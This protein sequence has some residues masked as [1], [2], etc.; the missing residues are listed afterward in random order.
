MAFD[1]DLPTID[2]DVTHLPEYWHSVERNHDAINSVLKGTV[3][4]LSIAYLTR[5]FVSTVDSGIG[6]LQNNDNIML[7]LQDATT[8]IETAAQNIPGSGVPTF[9]TS[10]LLWNINFFEGITDLFMGYVCSQWQIIVGLGSTALNVIT[11]TAPYLFTT[12]VVLKLAPNILPATKLMVDKVITFFAQKY[13]DIRIGKLARNNREKIHAKY[14]EL[15]EGYVTSAPTCSEFSIEELI[16]KN[17]L[18]QEMFDNLRRYNANGTTLLNSYTYIIQTTD[19]ATTRLLT[20][21]MHKELEQNKRYSQYTGPLSRIVNNRYASFV[22]SIVAQFEFFIPSPRQIYWIGNML[23]FGV[24][25]ILRIR[26]VFKPPTLPFTLSWSS[27]P[28]MMITAANSLRKSHLFNTWIAK[29]AKDVRSIIAGYLNTKEMISMLGKENIRVGSIPIIIAVL[30]FIIYCIE[31]KHV[32]PDDTFDVFSVVKDIHTDDV[33]NAIRKIHIFSKQKKTNNARDFINKCDEDGDITQLCKKSGNV[34]Q[35]IFE[36]MYEAGD[37]DK[38]TMIAKL[39]KHAP[40]FELLKIFRMMDVNRADIYKGIPSNDRDVNIATV[41]TG[42]EVRDGFNPIGRDKNWCKRLLA[43]KNDNKRNRELFETLRK[44]KI[45]VRTIGGSPLQERQYKIICSILLHQNTP[46]IGNAIHYNNPWWIIPKVNVAA[47]YGAGTEDHNPFKLRWETQPSLNEVYDA[48]LTSYTIDEWRTANLSPFNDYAISNYWSVHN[49][50]GPFIDRVAVTKPE[51]LALLAPVCNDGS[52]LS[53]ISNFLDAK[54]STGLDMFLCGIAQIKYID[55]RAVYKKCEGLASRGDNLDTGC[56]CILLHHNLLDPNV[57]R[58]WTPYRTIVDN[59]TQP[60]RVMHDLM[61]ASRK[62]M[63]N[64][65]GMKYL[66]FGNLFNMFVAYV[67]AM[68]ELPEHLDETRWV[69]QAWRSQLTSDKIIKNFFGDFKNKP[70]DEIRKCAEKYEQIGI[71]IK[72]IA[73]ETSTLW[74]I[75]KPQN[76]P[77][78]DETFVAQNA[79]FS[80]NAYDHEYKYIQR[81]TD[82]Q[83]TGIGFLD[84]LWFGEQHRNA[85]P[86]RADANWPWNPAFTY[87]KTQYIECDLALVDTNAEHKK[88]FDQVLKTHLSPLTIIHIGNQRTK[89]NPYQCGKTLHNVV[90]SNDREFTDV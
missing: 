72:R 77:E 33:C 2:I 63:L 48:I 76:C 87:K 85:S 35:I 71:R 27:I 37:T 28:K 84:K 62:T 17:K 1:G 14:G 41:W 75:L 81:D 69:V 60:A 32:L 51:L 54:N 73:F 56:V 67:K 23:W 44:T 42:D 89:L 64:R 74:D 46:V 39:W 59:A 29:N 7:Y 43:V 55:K 6:F 4:C 86:P 80:K 38:K 18:A 70:N 47:M 8:T 34:V 50:Q 26:D 45:T 53:I 52:I 19:G 24:K 16:C 83:L 40:T 61:E 30:G 49:V 13:N 11:I 15:R 90:K 3:G 79:D 25:Q 88:N 66:L 36:A 20:S 21:V 31:N 9:D 12:L 82:P 10:D 22:T 5:V 57:G 65:I 58:P 78:N 68:K